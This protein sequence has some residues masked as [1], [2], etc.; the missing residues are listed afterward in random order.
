[1]VLGERIICFLA[2]KVL[3][4]YNLIYMFKLQANLVYPG[5]YNLLEMTQGRGKCIFLS[6]PISHVNYESISHNLII[7]FYPDMP[8]SLSLHVEETVSL[9]PLFSVVRI[10]ENTVLGKED[11]YRKSECLWASV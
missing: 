11:C 7:T 10:K 6:S 3:Y 1:M 4:I 5:R 8:L 9:G 2:S